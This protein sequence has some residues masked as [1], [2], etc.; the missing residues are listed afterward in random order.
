[1][2]NFTENVGSLP[3]PYCSMGREG[4][5]EKKVTWLE[6][7]F[8]KHLPIHSSR[9]NCHACYSQG[10]QKRRKVKCKECDAGLCTGV[11]KCITKSTNCD[12]LRSTRRL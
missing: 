5:V 11:S 9:V 4:A 10:I 2:E 6:V 1:M 3:C 8:S 7:N 12:I